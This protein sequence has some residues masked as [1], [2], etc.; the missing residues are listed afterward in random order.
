MDVGTNSVGWAATDSEYNVLKFN[1]NATWGIYLFDEAKNAADRRVSRTARRRLQ[2]KKQRVAMLQDFFAKEI[3]DVDDQFYVRLKESQL[4]SDDKTTG[5][6]NHLFVGGELNDKSYNTKYPTIHHLIC[7]LMEST[8][9]HDPRLVYMACSYILSHRGHFLFDVDENNV[10]KVTDFQ[11]IYD[12]FMSWFHSYEIDM[13]WKCSADAFGVIMK[14]KQS[15][16]KK[17]KDF[18]DLLFDGKK[19]ADEE[20]KVS[21][22]SIIS[23]LSGRKTKLSDLFLNEA[24]QTLENEAISITSLS[25]KMSWMPCQ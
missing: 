8:D 5:I 12:G 2:R 19:P 20:G 18:F 22:K 1:G 3:S 9:P 4:W 23:F 25:L 17:E 13:P 15:V 7:E 11:N 14:K 10:D 6:D 24:Y 16:G 21:V